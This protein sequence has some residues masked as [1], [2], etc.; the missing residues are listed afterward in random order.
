MGSNPTA[1][2]IH[3]YSIYMTKVKVMAIDPFRLIEA[4]P[5]KVFHFFYSRAEAKA[6]RTD[7]EYRRIEDLRQNGTSA[8]TLLDQS[9]GLT[10]KE[11]DYQHDKVSK[12]FRTKPLWALL[13][14]KSKAPRRLWVNAHAALLR[15]R[16]GYDYSAV[17]DF[18]SWHTDHVTRILTEYRE[19]SRGHPTYMA[20]EEWDIVLHGIIDAFKAVGEAD[21]E[22]MDGEEIQRRVDFAFRAL[23]TY[24]LSLW[25]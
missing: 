15:V 3:T 10:W 11:L 24:Y 7:D 14:V 23:A 8:K 18:H 19:H 1:P 5:E 21:R 17:H 2:T 13:M 4:P 9:R 6:Y 20:E 25:D 12:F 22:A 16:K